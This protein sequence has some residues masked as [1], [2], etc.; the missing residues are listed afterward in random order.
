MQSVKREKY[1]RFCIFVGKKVIVKYAMEMSFIS[2]LPSFLLSVIILLN[3]A[4]LVGLGFDSRGQNVCRID[5]CFFR[6][7]VIFCLSK[8]SE[9]RLRCVRCPK[10]I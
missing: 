1:K 8:Y 6:S 2:I 10:N 5:K 4:V 7:L 3:G 9:A